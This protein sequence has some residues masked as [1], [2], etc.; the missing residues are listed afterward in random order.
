M[1]HPVQR[2]IDVLMAVCDGAKT[3]D[4]AG[5][6]KADVPLIHFDGAP[7]EVLEDS[8]IARRLV[9]YHRQLGEDLTKA[10]QELA[11]AD[12]LGAPIGDIPGVVFV[13]EGYLKLFTKKTEKVSTDEALITA[14]VRKYHHRDGFTYVEP[15][16]RILHLKVAGFRMAKRTIDWCAQNYRKPNEHV[17][18]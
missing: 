8:S 3:R 18:D 6:S 9:K 14:G 4:N 11:D 5:F 2:A 7:V 13:E 15:K 12:K 17:Q 1:T 16:E 10:L